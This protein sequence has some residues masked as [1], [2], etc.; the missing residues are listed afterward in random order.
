[1]LE[2]TSGRMVPL[3]YQRYWEN[4]EV[5]VSMEDG[6]QPSPI[7]VTSTEGM[8]S[9]P[10]KYPE[11]PATPLYPKNPTA[12]GPVAATDTLPVRLGM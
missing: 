2:D 10:E 11:A 8:V 4:P 9:K 12:M 7:V 3:L 6:R 1:M 5:A